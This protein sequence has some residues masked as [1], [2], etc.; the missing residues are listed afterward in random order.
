MHRTRIRSSCTHRRISHRNNLLL[1]FWAEMKGT[2]TELRSLN[3][4]QSTGIGHAN[5]ISQQP[6]VQGSTKGSSIPAKVVC[7]P[8]CFKKQTV[9]TMKA[10]HTSLGHP[11]TDRQGSTICNSFSSPLPA[12]ASIHRVALLQMMYIPTPPTQQ[13]SSSYLTKKASSYLPTTL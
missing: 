8:P 5:H 9:A 12:H 6:Q 4:H 11:T 2:L 1:V 13:H 7:I 3:F 10:V